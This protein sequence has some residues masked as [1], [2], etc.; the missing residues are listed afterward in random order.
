MSSTSLGKDQR[1]STWD[2]LPQEL[3]LLI[4]QAVMQDDGTPSRLATVSREW[5]AYVEPYNFAR[6][7]LTP[8]RLADFSPMIHRNRALV[9]YVW[10]CLELDDYDC[11]KCAPTRAM[12]ADEDEW[13]DAFAISGTDHCPIVSAFQSLL[14]ILSTWDSKREL[15]LDI[16][17]YS[18]SDSEHCFKYLTFMPDTPSDI[19]DGGDMDKETSSKVCHDPQHGW[20]DGFRSSAP[21]E[22]A[23]LKVFH[24]IM[25]EGPFHDE[26]SERRWWDQ[27]PSVPAVTTLLLRQQNRRR[28]KPCSLA[29]MFARF[30]KLK[31]IHYEPWREWDSIQ[32]L[33]DIG[34]YCCIPNPVSAGSPFP[35]YIS[36]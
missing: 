27:L 19:L 29:H 1:K 12:F 3:Q 35:Y 34:G 20:F 2:G 9:G 24:S 8:S 14:S 16:S 17:I 32:R 28:W 22:K 31:E 21:P 7:R 5:Q 11:T 13:G 30:P 18:P 10:F 23:L 26:L 36:A 4:L 25:S 15:T 6:I 33:T